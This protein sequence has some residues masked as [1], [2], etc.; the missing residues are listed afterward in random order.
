MMKESLELQLVIGHV[1]EGNRGHLPL[2]QVSQRPLDS[3]CPTAGMVPPK[4]SCLHVGF[5]KVTRREM[6]NFIA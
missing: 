6:G 3:F 4:L 5:S 2:D 1:R